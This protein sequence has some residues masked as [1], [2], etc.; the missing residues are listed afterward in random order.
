VCS[1]PGG[2]NFWS[3]AYSQRTKLMYIP[4]LEGCTNITRPDPARRASSTA[5]ISATTDG[6]RAAYPWSILQPAS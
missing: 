1:V 6:F 5:A 3:A 4:E 2:N